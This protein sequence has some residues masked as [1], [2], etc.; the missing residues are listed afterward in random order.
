MRTL[1]GALITE[2]GLEG[3]RPGYLVSIAFGTPLYLSTIGDVTWGGHN[4][5][6]SDTKVSGLVRDVSANLE[7]GLS[8]GNSD[9]VIGALVRAEKITDRAI[10]INTVYAGATAAGDVVEEFNGVGNGAKVGNRVEVSCISSP[11]MAASAPRRRISPATGFN[12]LM[13][14]GTTLTMGGETYELERV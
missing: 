11:S 3:T 5:L 2:L 14:A 6:A 4:W 9:G 8:L 12:I 7:A 13:P 1:T 10:V